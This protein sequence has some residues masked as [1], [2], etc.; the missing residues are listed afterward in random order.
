MSAE[1]VTYV[2][3]SAIVKL[4]VEEPASGALR[5]YL[6][7]RTLVTSALAQA[8]VARALLPLGPSVVG[9]GW[10]ALRVFELARVTSDVLV[11]AGRLQP[12][13]LR[14]LDAIHV[15]TALRFGEQLARVVT[16][17]SR[18]AEAARG[19]GCSVTAP[20]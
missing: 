9:R 11:A 2:D 8:E 15:A 6:K 14:T 4:V 1:R 19:A 20:A 16:Y 12:A 13:G 18:M 7:G 3:S 5:R 17:D 10:K